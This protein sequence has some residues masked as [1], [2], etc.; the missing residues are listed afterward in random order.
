MTDTSTR[1]AFRTTDPAT[2]GRPYLQRPQRRRRRGEAERAATAQR[3]WRRTSFDQRAVPMKKAA[4]VLR[5]P[6]RGVRRPHDGRDGQTLK[7]GQAEVEKCAFNCDYF[8]DS[9]EKYLAPG[10]GRL[11]AGRRHSSPTIPSASCSP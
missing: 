3:D 9:A 5:R 7:E 10:A 11:S 2:R 4:A 1:P 6:Q 8:A